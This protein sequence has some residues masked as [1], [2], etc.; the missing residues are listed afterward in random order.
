MFPKG[1]NFLAHAVAKKKLT[2]Q[3][4]CLWQNIF[5]A[6]FYFKTKDSTCN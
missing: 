1:T 3:F 4:A 2:A 6:S 5:Q